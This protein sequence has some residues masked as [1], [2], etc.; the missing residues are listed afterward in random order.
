MAINT[1]ERNLNSTGD[2]ANR[3]F[4]GE[5]DVKVVELLGYEPEG[6]TLNR[7]KVNTE[8]EIITA[9]GL[10]ETLQELVQR[11][12]PLAGAMASNAG[13]RVVGVTMPSTAVTGPITSAQSIA[14]KNVGGISYTQRVA[15]EN[16][17]AIQSNIINCTGV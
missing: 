11:L 2:L 12:A 6:N 7:I 13:L 3:S 1:R 14:E 8:G 4:D 5:F 15:L 17:T 16:N 10:V 9:P